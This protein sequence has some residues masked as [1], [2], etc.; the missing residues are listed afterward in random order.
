MTVPVSIGEGRVT[1][2]STSLESEGGGMGIVPVVT[3][4]VVIAAVV[5]GAFWYIRKKPPAAGGTP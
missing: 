1:E 3:A 4:I 5:G 2:Y